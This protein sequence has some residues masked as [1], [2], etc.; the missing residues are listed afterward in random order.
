MRSLM[1]QKVFDAQQR[2][3]AT[4]VRSGLIVV[5][6]G[7]FGGC[8]PGDVVTPDV[9][10]DVGPIDVPVIDPAN[11]DC[12]LVLRRIAEVQKELQSPLT[13]RRAAA[14]RIAAQYP[15]SEVSR[16]TLLEFM[17]GPLGEM[18]PN[19]DESKRVADLTN[20]VLLCDPLMYELVTHQ[21]YAAHPELR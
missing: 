8:T 14:R 6:I 10:L 13:N 16:R 7:C 17:R 9:V 12:V 11:I 19:D 3:R 4:L 18:V 15:H 1:G 20:A 21:Y 2:V 5:A